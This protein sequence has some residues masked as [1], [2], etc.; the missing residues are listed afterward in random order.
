MERI[1]V[2]VIRNIYCVG[3]N[4]GLHAAEL[5]NAI[6]DSPMIFMKPTHAAVE[7]DGSVV[8]LPSGFGSVHYEA[9][10]VV[11][12]GRPYTLGATADELINGF[13]LGIDLTMRDVQ[14]E[15]KMKQH[16]WLK[17][18]GFRASAP[19]TAFRPLAEPLAELAAHEFSLWINDSEKQRGH[20]RDMIFDLQLLID[21]IG[22]HYG[23]DQ[24]DI[25]FT[26]TPAGVGQV[27]DGDRLE[28]IWGDAVIGSCRIQ[29]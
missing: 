13:A 24:G 5:G 28:L 15:L 14:D 6:P 19:M 7:M 17:A 16:P 12:I 9:E 2:N 26:G 18:K 10:L 3:R 1:T 27:Y 29:L 4:Y 25:I 21:H 8:S 11:R 22:D 23:L 20:I